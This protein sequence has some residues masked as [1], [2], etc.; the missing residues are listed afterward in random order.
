MIDTL[1][2]GLP[3]GR[4]ERA[5]LDL[6]A[7]GGIHV[8]PTARGY[9]PHVRFDCAEAKVAENT[10]PL[11]TISALVRIGARHRRG[12]G[13]VLVPVGAWHQRGLQLLLGLGLVMVGAWHR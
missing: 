4:M 11:S 3:K 1:R 8:T 13:S 12:L 9:R 10:T 6:L 2:I 5:V 7:A